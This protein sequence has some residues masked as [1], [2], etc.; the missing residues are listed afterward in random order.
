[1]LVCG[2]QGCGK[3][4]V[5]KATARV[6]SLPLVRLDFAE[7]FAARSPEHAIH[8]ATRAV[9]AVAPVVLWVDEIEKGLGADGGRRAARARLRR[10]PHLA[11]GAAGARLRRRHRQRGRAP[12]PGAR[13]PRALRRGVLRRPPLRRR[14]ARRSSRVHLGA[15]RA[16]PGALPRRGAREGA[17]A[18]VGRRDRADG[19]RAASSARTPRQR[20]LTE[21][22]PARRRARAR[23]A[24]DALRGEDPGA[25][26]VGADA[27]APRL[28]RPA[29]AGSRS[30]T[31]AGVP[32]GVG[33]SH[34]DGP[35]VDDRAGRRGRRRIGRARVVPR[36]RPAVVVRGVSPRGRGDAVPLSARVAAP[37][38]SSGSTT[39]SSR[40]ASRRS[41]RRSSSTTRTSR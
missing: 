41:T 17:R 39:P 18:L 29:D 21:D 4:L 19:R 11:A 35:V 38:G 20:D 28:G 6:L 24:G 9:E 30:A 16:R 23:A 15:A 31:D 12:A 1:M 7:V 27:G 34:V 14:S 32:D 26:P 36:D 3:S 22:A 5:S 13:A 8:E 10:V 33:S 40:S 2:V 37:A 25:A